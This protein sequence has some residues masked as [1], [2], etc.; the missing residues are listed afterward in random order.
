MTLMKTPSH[1]G[2]VLKELYLDPLG[3]SPIALAR[4]LHVP[5]TRIER[6]VREETAVT[7]DTAMRLARA[8]GTTPE[9]WMNLQ[10]A[11]DLARARD[12]VDVS[13]IAPVAA[14]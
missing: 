11:W 14:A 4:R 7:A 3:L 13:D 12:T 5:R 6:L 9:Y 1:P 10:R 8:F 2:E